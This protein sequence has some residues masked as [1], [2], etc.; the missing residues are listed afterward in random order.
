MD[1]LI[2]LGEIAVGLTI[3]CYMAFIVGLTVRLVLILN[4]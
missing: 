4:K 2:G 3:L 1:I